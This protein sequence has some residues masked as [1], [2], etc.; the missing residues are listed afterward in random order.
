LFV[1]QAC[2]SDLRLQELAVDLTVVGIDITTSGASGL[3]ITR[4]LPSRQRIQPKD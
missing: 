1:I 3:V 4:W 2:L